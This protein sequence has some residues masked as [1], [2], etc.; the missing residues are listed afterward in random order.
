MVNENEGSRFKKKKNKRQFIEFKSNR[1]KWTR[2]ELIKL[3]GFNKAEVKLE[4]GEIITRSTV[5]KF[6]WGITKKVRRKNG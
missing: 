2:A 6:R 1:N 4:S 3:N 5:K